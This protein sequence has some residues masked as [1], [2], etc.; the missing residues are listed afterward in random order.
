MELY[1]FLN[2]IAGKRL[3]LRKLVRGFIMGTTFIDIY[4][5]IILKYTH[6]EGKAFGVL[7]MDY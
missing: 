1:I 2:L 4:S 7:L 5:L 6:M 3:K